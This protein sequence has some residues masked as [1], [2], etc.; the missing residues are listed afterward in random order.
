[1]TDVRISGVCQA[2]KVSAPIDRSF[3]TL[4]RP[5]DLFSL[6]SKDKKRRLVFIAPKVMHGLLHQATRRYK[7][8]RKVILIIKSTAKL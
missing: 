1:M 8:K 6:V 3:D 5:I 2:L 7:Q 4:C